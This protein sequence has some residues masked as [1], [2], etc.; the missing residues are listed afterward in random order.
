MSIKQ[1]ID[2]ILDESAQFAEANEELLNA[3]ADVT[4]KTLGE[5][6]GQL[7]DGINQL[8]DGMASTEY[9]DPK[10]SQSLQSA[11]SE[12]ITKFTQV[13][14]EINFAPTVNVDLSP[15]QAEL[16]KS[17]AQGK[18]LQ[19]LME[20]FANGTGKQEEISNLIMLIGQKQIAA[21][22]KISGMADIRPELGAINET[23]NKPRPDKWRGKITKRLENNGHLNGLIDEFEIEAIKK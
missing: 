11:M 12:A 19:G 2:A 17:T 8:F 21:F 10:L 23:L 7:N 5:L 18:M 9:Y 20:K 13:K 4:I 6:L 1:Q 14:H 16:S 22:E 15:L 3:K